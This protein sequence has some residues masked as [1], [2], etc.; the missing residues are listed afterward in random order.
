MHVGDVVQAR[1][2]TVLTK[3]DVEAYAVWDHKDGKDG[4]FL[5]FMYLD[6][7]PRENKYGHAAVWGLLSGYQKADGGRSYPTVCMV[8]NLAK[9]TPTRPALMSHDSVVTFFVRKPYSTCH[10]LLASLHGCSEKP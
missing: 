7:F 2:G 1:V 10:A 8:A 9:P 6:L 5:G 4:D 3:T